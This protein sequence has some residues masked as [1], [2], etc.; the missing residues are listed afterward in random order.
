MPLSPARPQ[1]SSP[2]PPPATRLLPTYRLGGAWQMAID[3]WLLEAG[4][5]A[6]RFY[7]WARPCLS[8]GRHQRRLRPAWLEL[9]NAGALELVRRPSGGQAVL[10]GGDLTYALIWP[11]A[12]ADRRLAYRLACGWLQQAFAELGLP[13]RFGDQPAGLAAASCFATSTAADLVHAAGAGSGAEGV[14]RIG[15]AQLWRRGS[16][17]QHGS[18]QLQPE[19]ELW[20]RLFDQPPPR[21]PALG[22]DGAELERRLRQ[23]AERHLPLPGPLLQQP[24]TASELTALVPQL[25]AY[26]LDADPSLTCTSPEATIE[27]TT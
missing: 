25:A 9:A 26:R 12:P 8:L 4:Q 1:P 23:A 5:P 11:E 19:A 22:I 17:L 20:R 3:A 21:L 16:L 14:K 13:L 10:H 15:S 24:L 27:R 7:R 18:I 2:A 6:L